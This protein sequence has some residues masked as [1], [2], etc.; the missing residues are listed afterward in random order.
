M[1]VELWPHL[2]EF[3]SEPFA[4]AELATGTNRRPLALPWTF[5][6][7]RRNFLRCFSVVNDISFFLTTYPTAF[8][9]LRTLTRDLLD[10]RGGYLY[11]R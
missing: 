4:H 8:L 6:R 9:P 5:T 3:Y 7:I 11:L 2:I 1:E 10:S